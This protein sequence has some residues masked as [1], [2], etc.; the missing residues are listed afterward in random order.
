MPETA[1]FDPEC[2]YGFPPARLV[3]DDARRICDLAMEWLRPWDYLIA[4]RFIQKKNPK[5]WQP[6]RDLARQCVGAIFTEYL[7]SVYG[8]GE[9]T[10][11]GCLKG[12][13]PEIT[14]ALR[15]VGAAALRARLFMLTL[16]PGD[17]EEADT[18]ELW[19]LNPD[20]QREAE[21]GA[22]LEL[23][24]ARRKLMAAL[25]A[26]DVSPAE[27]PKPETSPPKAPDSP[28]RERRYKRGERDAVAVAE[29]ARNPSLTNTQLAE[30][31][32]CNRTTLASA[33]KTPMLAKA[34]EAIKSS[35]L[36]YARG[37]E[38]RDRRADD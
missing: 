1:Q 3:R 10:Y 11:L 4:R 27:P 18:S 31:L 38:W 19:G 33:E 37:D 22:L 6:V 24:D 9:S 20:E 5:V 15:R 7:P 25:N 23:S 30:M 2:V 28:K 26:Q 13:S 8:A 35:K 32:G 36:D 34:R 17:G 14:R 29:L 12:D 21:Y 16:H